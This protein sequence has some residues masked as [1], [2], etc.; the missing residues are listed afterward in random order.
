ML[1]ML[2]LDF[3]T[4]T[5]AAVKAARAALLAEPLGSNLRSA[6]EKSAPAFVLREVDESVR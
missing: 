4:G 3:E 1:T 2:A 6:I 5:Q